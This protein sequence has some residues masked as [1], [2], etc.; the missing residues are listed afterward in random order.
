MNENN[1]TP[2]DLAAEI[3]DRMIYDTTQL[4]TYV[5]RHDRDKITEWIEAAITKFAV[6]LI[7]ENIKLKWEL[8]K[9]SPPTAHES[10]KVMDTIWGKVDTNQNGGLGE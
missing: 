6:R 8:A 9:F 3:A 7:A 5:F 4:A 2:K 10:D 1:P